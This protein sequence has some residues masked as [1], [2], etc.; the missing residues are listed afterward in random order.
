MQILLKE[1]E[2]TGPYTGC[3]NISIEQQGAGSPLKLEG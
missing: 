2:V 1:K 3:S